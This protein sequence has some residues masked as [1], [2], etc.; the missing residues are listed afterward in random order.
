MRPVTAGMMLLSGWGLPKP[1]F[2]RLGEQATTPDRQLKPPSMH[3]VR[4]PVVEGDAC[5]LS[6]RALVSAVEGGFGTRF[7]SGSGNFQT[8]SDCRDGGGAGVARLGV[9]SRPKSLGGDLLIISV[10]GVPYSLTCFLL[11][12]DRS[13]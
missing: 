2:N 10:G 1:G 8:G 6:L 12:V 13:T 3:Y 5:G 7:R 11:K 4:N 9:G